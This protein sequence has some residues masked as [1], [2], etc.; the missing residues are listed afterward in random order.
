MK[1]LYGVTTAMTTPFYE[2]GGVNLDALAGEVEMLI[3]KGVQCL[4]PNG[5]TGE[6]L[7]M[8]VEE[9]KAVAETVVRTAAGRLPVFIH[10][11][12]MNE[13]D[14]VVLAQHAERIG[15]DGIG[16]VTPQFFGLDAYEMVAFYLRVAGKVSSD[17][18]IYLYNIPQCAVNDISAEVAQ[19]IADKASNV[20]G[21]KYSFPDVNR[22]MDYLKINNW[23][24]SVM[25]GNDRVFSAYMVLGCDGT[26]SGISGVF[27]EPFVEVYRAIVEKDFDR[28][29]IWQRHAARI[30][31]I[32]HGGFNMSYF[33][34][35]LK[36][37][38]MDGGH[39]RM[40]QMDISGEEVERLA[41]QLQSFCDDTG[42]A[43]KI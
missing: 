15:A 4:Y 3:Q 29:R 1:K 28:A 12:A 13:E 23:N 43:L 16:V 40:P 25:H 38:G 2:N 30:A 22:T 14:V 10:C 36:L 37:R 41:E 27:P 33:K 31:D 7:R 35:G 24:F 34:E 32:L 11:G 17:F 39:M 9:R 18:P 20:I 26:V 8:S 6:M 19:R 42:I 21:I 5:T